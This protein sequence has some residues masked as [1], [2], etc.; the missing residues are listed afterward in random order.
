M[1]IKHTTLDYEG[2]PVTI[3][4][5]EVL[6]AEP[7]YRDQVWNSDDLEW[8]DPEYP[9]KEFGSECLSDLEE[10]CWYWDRI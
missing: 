4:N 8:E 3:E 5:G 7:P 9:D 10:R 1:M 2:D 6:E